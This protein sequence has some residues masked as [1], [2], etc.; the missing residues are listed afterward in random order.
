MFHKQTQT[1][2][3]TG[4]WSSPWD[5]NFRGK[6]RYPLKAKKIYLFWSEGTFLRK[7]AEDLIMPY[8]EESGLWTL[9]FEWQAT[10]ESSDRKKQKKRKAR[11]KR[12]SKNT[13][14]ESAPISTLGIHAIW[15]WGLFLIHGLSPEGLRQGKSHQLLLANPRDWVPVGPQDPLTG[16][17]HL[18]PAGVQI[19]S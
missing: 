19:F 13:E 14:D 11:E 4:A 12:T 1:K 2:A 17:Q 3:N 10:I 5:G 8:R 15:G 6:I 18:F 9:S 7:I 16:A